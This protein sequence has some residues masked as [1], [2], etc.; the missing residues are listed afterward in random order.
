VACSHFIFHTTVICLYLQDVTYLSLCYTIIVP[1]LTSTLPGE[2][3]LNS[4]LASK[5]RPSR[6]PGLLAT[7]AAYLVPDHIR[8][9]FASD[10]WSVHVPLTFL[11][12]AYCS[13]SN[14]DHSSVT[15]SISF[16]SSSNKLFSIPKPLSR[17]GELE[18]SFEEW[19]QSWRRLSSLIKDFLPSEYRAWCIHRDRIRDATNRT[20]CWSTWLAYDTDIRH[21]ATQEAIDP[22]LFHDHIWNDVRERDLENRVLKRISK[23]ASISASGKPKVSASSF[24]SRQYSPRYTPYNRPGAAQDG[25]KPFRSSQRSSTRCFICGD[26]S[27]NHYTRY[28]N[29]TSLVNGKE[30]HIKINRSAGDTIRR[31]IQGRRYCFAWNGASGCDRGNNC[32]NGQHLCTLCGDSSHNAQLCANI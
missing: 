9:K 15:D 5:K 3:E 26:P 7:G 27:P 30:C 18:L 20:E 1:P 25:N 11:T 19:D 28:C 8:K 22:S 31:D 12:D 4:V 29:A 24:A 2:L 6:Q 21:R 32:F 17:A 23:D 14:P 10:G 16:D 13:H